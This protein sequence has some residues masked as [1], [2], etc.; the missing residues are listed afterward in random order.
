[1]KLSAYFPASSILGEKSFYDA[2]TPGWKRLSI[3][4]NHSVTGTVASCDR[5]GTAQVQYN[6]DF[7][8]SIDL[9][10]VVDLTSNRL[11]ALQQRDE[12]KASVESIRARLPYDISATTPGFADF[13]ALMAV[14]SAAEAAGS[15]RRPVTYSRSTA[16]YTTVSTGYR[17]PRLGDLYIGP[18]LCRTSRE[19]ITFLKLAG[20]AGVVRVSLLSDTTMTPEAKPLQGQGLAVFCAKIKAHIQKEA[21]LLTSYG[22]HELASIAGVTQAISLN[23]HSDEGGWLRALLKS[24]SYPPTSGVL[25]GTG[26]EFNGMPLQECIHKEDILTKVVADYLSTIA[27]AHVSDTIVNGGTSTYERNAD[28]PACIDSYGTLAH[29][30]DDVMRE[31]IVQ[32]CARDSMHTDSVS[33]CSAFSR[34]FNRRAIDRHLE[35]GTLIAPWWWVETAPLL[36]K[37]IDGYD[38]PALHGEITKLPLFNVIDVSH[39]SPVLDG[40]GRVVP[41]ATTGIKRESG[42]FRTEG[43]SYL[44]N[45][46]YDKS[47]T[48]AR[49]A[50]N[51]F[52][53]TGPEDFLF[54]NPA[55]KDLGEVRWVTPHNPMPHPLEGITDGSVNLDVLSTDWATD[56]TPH[57]LAHGTVDSFLGLFYVVNESSSEER[58]T[59][60]ACPRSLRRQLKLSS[61]HF[62]RLFRISVKSGK[63]EPSAGPPPTVGNPPPLQTIESDDDDSVDKI[64]SESG[65]E[66]HEEKV[67]AGEDDSD[68]DGVA[69]EL[70]GAPSVVEKADP[71]NPLSRP[72]QPTTDK[73][74]QGPERVFSANQK[75][76]AGSTAPV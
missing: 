3:G 10:S 29:D 32:I 60:R 64:D 49:F 52:E 43:A 55:A 58:V 61:P 18:S 44:F 72:K 28:E 33:D 40:K 54:G 8:P 24:A 1:M 30:I 53:K 42:P 37:R 63:T 35:C 46:R 22:A 51:G 13:R 21:N 23:G 48:L 65:K 9:G 4:C 5:Y 50:F 67:L 19:F 47:E 6:L 7:R 74:T 16:E 45:A 27:L 12:V 25:I 14:V 71:A 39:D 62:Q 70:A 41:G 36:T 31:W 59:F 73:P 15:A 75:K 68:A 2:P 26:N 57:D 66:E 20:Q 38:T 69:D 34:T 76:D 11:I 56:P 17:E